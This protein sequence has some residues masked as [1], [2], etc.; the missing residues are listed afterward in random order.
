MD[1]KT[2]LTELFRRS[3]EALS[4]ENIVRSNIVKTGNELQIAGKRIDTQGSPVHLMAVGKAAG[5]MIRGF[6]QA[7]GGVDELS[8]ILVIAQQ[9]TDLTDLPAGK[10]VYGSHPVPGEGSLTA[11]RQ[12][13]EFFR[14]VPAEGTL[15]TLISGG[16]SSLMC[17]PAERITISELN[18][19]F[20]LLNNSGATIREVNAVR[21]HL[22]QIK[23]G[24]LLRN[25]DPGVTLID[26]VISDVPDDDLSVIGSGPTTP[27]SSTFQ[28]AYHVLL[29]YDLWKEVSDSV[30]DHIEKG[31]TGET[32]HTVKKNEDP[33][34]D[35]YSR[36]IGS[37]RKLAEKAGSLAGDDGFDVRIADEAFNEDVERMAKKITTR[38]IAV[39]DDDNG[40]KSG[41]NT[42]NK[43]PVLLIFYGESTVNV[44]GGGRGGRNQEL[45]LRGAMHIAGKDHITLLSAGTDGIDGP[46]DAAGAVVDGSTIPQAKAGG[47]EPE[48]F[49]QDNDSY[50]FH[51]RMETLLCTGPTGNNLMDI[52]LVVI[53]RR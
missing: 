42:G 17:L 4:P 48:V 21:K 34:E 9:K 47:L 1:F 18:D 53:D 41:D 31:L 5:P 49:L 44:T 20:R 39:A 50:T 27:D 13:V 52:V 12:A 16:T 22:S 6:M 3:L 2:Y 23:G 14:A 10:I 15:V 35:H 19:V 43:Q 32:V 26:L 24:Q 7:A 45:A 25:L 29:E 36:V 33:L 40:T 28:D 51:R 46:T 8:D 38:A 11:G 37:A 30:R